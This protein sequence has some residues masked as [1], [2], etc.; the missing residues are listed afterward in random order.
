VLV[1]SGN[2]PGSAPNFLRV[3]HY[4]HSFYEHGSQKKDSVS[5]YPISLSPLPGPSSPIIQPRPYL[6][7]SAPGNWRIPLTTILYSHSLKVLELKNHEHWSESKGN[8]ISISIILYPR[9][10]IAENE[11]LF[12][13]VKSN[14]TIQGREMTSNQG[15]FHSI[16]KRTR[17]SGKAVD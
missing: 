15:G 5:T 16:F 14:R 12:A 1:E 10:D 9:D 13:I 11:I 17:N 3:F 4:F 6:L 2:V 8:T 7:H